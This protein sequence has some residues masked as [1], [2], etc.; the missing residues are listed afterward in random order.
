[1]QEKTRMTTSIAMRRHVVCADAAAELA[2]YRE[3]KE[4][5]ER[6]DVVEVVGG[7]RMLKRRIGERCFFESGGHDDSRSLDLVVFLHGSRDIALMQALED[8]NLLQETR[9]RG[10][11]VA[12]GQCR[13]TIEDPHPDER[14]GSLC[15]GE[16]YWGI[17]NSED[18]QADI[19]YV[20]A[21]V[22]DVRS[23]VAIRH[24][25]AIGH[26]NGGV[27]VLLLALAHPS[28]FATVV[29]HQ[30]GLGWDPEC[31]FDFD[32]LEEGERKPRM[33]FY[34]GE[35][36]EYRLPCQNGHAIFVDEGFDST[37][38]VEPGLE[39]GYDFSC[40]PYILDWMGLEAAENERLPAAIY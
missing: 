1:M 22:A 19:D 4:A 14:F 18:A 5:Q 37:L 12:F 24:V 2:R 35:H 11:M 21:L 10:M 32:S 36:D 6:C 15:F 16:I 33:L 9:R 17:K 39:H 7:E 40:E 34:T 8:T 31:V 26:S 38:F 23:R 30:G 3:I 13:G 28:L 29:S 20:A 25:H 27:F